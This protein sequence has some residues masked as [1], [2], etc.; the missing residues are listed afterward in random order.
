MAVVIGID[1]SYTRLGMAVLEASEGFRGDT[2]TVLQ[3]G[4][5]RMN[6]QRSGVRKWLAGHMRECV[7]RYQPDFVCVE[8]VRLFSGKLAFISLPVILSLH[9]LIVTII[10]AA[11]P[12]PVFSVDTRAWKKYALDNPN[13]N[14]EDAV[15]FCK[16]MGIRKELDHDAADAFC[17]ALYA[18]SDSPKL[19]REV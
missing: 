6:G 8:R 19:K 2:V 13:A 4:S 1:Q 16:R 14:K 9:S 10:D 12:T 7:S 18:L 15:E 11:Y 3:V 5:Y 17:L